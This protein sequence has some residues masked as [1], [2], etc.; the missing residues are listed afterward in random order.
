LPA[1]LRL[2]VDGEASMRA[3]L[4][5]AL[6]LRGA[7]AFVQAR[8]EDAWLPVATLPLALAGLKD[9]DAMI[10]FPARSHPA[11]RL[12]SEYFCYPEKFNFIDLDTAQLAALL[13]PRCAS[14]TL[15][16][17]LTGLA[18]DSDPA[19]L[20]AG[21]GARNLLPGC[22][23]VINLF[24]KAG[25]PLQLSY[26]SADHPL[27]ADGAHAAAYEIHS[28]DAVRLVREGAATASVTHFAPLYSASGAAGGAGQQKDGQQSGGKH[29]WI[30][31]RDHAVAA[32]SPGHEMRIALID[33]DFRTTQ[34]G[35]ATLSTM[36][37][38]TNRDLPAQL[39]YG[40]PQGDLRTDEL[41]GVAPIR[42][43]RKPS[44][45]YRFDTAKGAHWRLISHLSLN[46]ANLTM[47]GLPDF[48]KMLALY[49]LPRSPSTQRLIAGIRGLEHGAVRA[50]VKT[51]PVSTLMPGIGI[52]LTVDEEAFAGSSLAVFARVLDHYFALNGQLNCFTRLQV[53][54]SLT[55]QEM[56]ACEPRH[57]S[58]P[59]A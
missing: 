57:S 38:C 29:Y 47:A 59:P 35:A 58:Q 5:D 51:A 15:H 56:L 46:H 11:L 36:L 3:A 45:S 19:R 23:P 6:M 16:V 9:E 25:A 52:R 1:R 32:V 37:T 7:C 10:P 26:T 41:S 8:G 2:F 14:F 34:T 55:G 33:A 44:P 13:P 53:V 4:V 48:Q 28:V 24:P 27:L 12:L 39:P 20:L 17:V 50:W 42:M 21:V 22:T 49:D 54:S 30:T 18:G 31:R 43:L 40:D